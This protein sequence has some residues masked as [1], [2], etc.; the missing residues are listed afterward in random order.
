MER[1]NGVP[2]E[3]RPR[4]TAPWADGRIAHLKTRWLEGVSVLA[5]SR[6][7]GISRN[8]VPGKIR[9]L[10]VV[11]LSSKGARGTRLPATENR[12]ASR[13]GPA[14]SPVVTRLGNQYSR[15]VWVSA[16]TLHVD[17]PRVDADVGSRQG[18]SFLEL[19]CRTCRWPVGDP[20]SRD[21]FFC[22]AEPV[23]GKPYCAAHC[24]R[25]YR[26][27]Q[28][29]APRPRSARLRR[30]MLKFRGIATYIKLGGETTMELQCVGESQ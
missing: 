28:E 20:G 27:A 23:Q 18:C 6:D 14:D 9:R 29:T 2:L 24:L 4:A 22:G 12:R 25:A 5:I 21:F 26:P 19:S 8:S 17:H 7:L 13:R 3:P 1:A 30:A 10:S 11:E 16:A 15:P